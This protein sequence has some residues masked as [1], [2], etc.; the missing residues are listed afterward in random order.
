MWTTPAIKERSCMWGP[1]VVVEG[2][3]GLRHSNADYVTNSFKIIVA[4]RQWI[5]EYDGEAVEGYSVKK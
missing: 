1:S 2:N 5:N 4:K 3:C